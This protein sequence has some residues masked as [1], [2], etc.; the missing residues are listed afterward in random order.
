MSGLKHETI[1]FYLNFREPNAKE[2]KNFLSNYRSNRNT[3]N[4]CG[5][6]KDQEYCIQIIKTTIFNTGSYA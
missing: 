2:E 3:F 1:L 5:S 4:H 6:N